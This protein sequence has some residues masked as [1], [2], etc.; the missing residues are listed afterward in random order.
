MSYIRPD[1]SFTTISTSTHEINIT[2]YIKSNYYH[3]NM[4]IRSTCLINID[5]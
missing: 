2:F 3:S 4:S 1:T 5:I